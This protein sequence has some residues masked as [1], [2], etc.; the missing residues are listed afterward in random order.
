[1][2]FRII[3]VLFVLT[4]IFTGLG[5]YT[6][7][8]LAAG[9]YGLT[10]ANKNPATMGCAALRAGSLRQLPSYSGTVETR[11]S[12]ASGT[13]ACDTKWSRTYNL[14][15]GDR[16][17]AA[18]LYCKDPSAYSFQHCRS[19]RSEHKIQSSQSVGIFTMMEPFHTK[20]TRSCG[21]VQDGT[22]PISVPI[23]L[24]DSWC[25]GTN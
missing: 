7:Q 21:S 13:N 2:K 5:L 6:Q 14:S 22:Q 17:V 24:G 18:T 16:Y 23:P 19:L 12:P 25:T 15:G 9:C 10:C 8:A 3:G 4:L 1:M 20:N 11:Y